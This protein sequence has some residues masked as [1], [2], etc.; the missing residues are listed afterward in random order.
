MRAKKKLYISYSTNEYKETAPPFHLIQY[1]DKIFEFNCKPEK[2]KEI[3]FNFAPTC[4]SNLIYIRFRKTK[5]SGLF[6]TGPNEIANPISTNQEVNIKCFTFN[7]VVLPSILGINPNQLLNRIVDFKE[8]AGEKPFNLL[9]RLNRSTSNP[10]KAV[11]QYFKPA[12]HKVDEIETDIKK[13]VSSMKAVSGNI[14]L[15]DIYREISMNKRT[16]QRK[17]FERT[18]LTPKEFCKILRFETASRK[19]IINKYNHFDVIFESG[20]YDQ[21]HYNK[22]FKKFLGLPPSEYEV[23]QKTI[24][25]RNLIK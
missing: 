15:S 7:P 24:L 12:F 11:E 1:I 14:K 9:S 2:G 23:R 8:V 19:L 25:F 5:V 20:Y 4:N 17:F 13:A 6:I 16:F 22:D 21:A 10:L 18:G 3:T